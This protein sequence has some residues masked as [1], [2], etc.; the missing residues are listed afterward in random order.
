MIDRQKP[1][2]VFLKII[3]DVRADGNGSSRRKEQIV[4]LL[5]DIDLTVRCS[6]HEDSSPGYLCEYGS[7]PLARLVGLCGLDS[8]IVQKCLNRIRDSPYDGY[9]YCRGEV[10][11]LTKRWIPAGVVI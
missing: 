9:G 2:P 4:A 5:K 8:S 11:R 6:A 3:A 7:R 1:D 10:D